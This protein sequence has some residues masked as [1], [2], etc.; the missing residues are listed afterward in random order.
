M[1]VFMNADDMAGRKI[2]ENAVVELEFLADPAKRRTVRGFKVHAYR[3]PRGSIASYY[4]ETNELMPVSFCDQ[5]AKMPSGKSIPV[6][7]R[8]M[9]EPL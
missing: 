9:A 6:L 4:P 7:V 3:I 5:L 2:A 1:V 8:P